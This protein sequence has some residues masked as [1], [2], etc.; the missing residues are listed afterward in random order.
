MSPPESLPPAPSRTSPNR[1]P[2]SPMAMR[3]RKWGLHDGHVVHPGKYAIGGFR[4]VVTEST[5][6]ASSA[7]T[8]PYDMGMRDDGRIQPLKHLHWLGY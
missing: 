5:V 2:A 6:V 8:S 1:I 3:A 4:P 7:G